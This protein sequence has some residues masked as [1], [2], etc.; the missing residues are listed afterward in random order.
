M[1]SALL[2][3]YNYC[4]G[5]HTCEVACQKE[6]GLAPDQFGIKL[7]QIGPDQVSE[8]KWQYDFFPS[9]TERCDLCAERVA[10]GRL[11]SC[12]KHCQAGCMEYGAVEE[13]ARKMTSKKMVLFV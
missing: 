7:N 6:H 10:V 4:T 13:L 2:I 5:C 12:V 1:Q 11:P 9:P 3:D 8:R